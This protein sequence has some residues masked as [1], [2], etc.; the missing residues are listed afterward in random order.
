M[1]GGVTTQRDS[2]LWTLEEISHLVSHSGHYQQRNAIL[3][4]G[5]LLELY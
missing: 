3:I 5:P 4:R 1:L 2:L